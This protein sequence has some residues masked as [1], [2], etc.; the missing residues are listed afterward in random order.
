MTCRESLKELWFIL[1]REIE[2]KLI[3]FLKYIKGS[4]KVKGNYLLSI[5]VEDRSRSCEMK[6]QHKSLT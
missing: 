5:H 2:K 3:T 6:L 4:C 1:V